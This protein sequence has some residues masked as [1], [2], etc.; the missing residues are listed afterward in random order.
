MKKYLL[1]F[2]LLISPLLSVAGEISP[3]CTYKGIPLYGKVKVVDSLADFQVKIV[4]SLADLKVQ[5]VSALP[6][7]CG[8]W[9]FVD[10]LPDFTVQFV[11]ALPDFTIQYVDALPGV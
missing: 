4:D 8:Q 1:V 3:S 7:S 10:S 5:K 9:E 6:N 11:D 2:I